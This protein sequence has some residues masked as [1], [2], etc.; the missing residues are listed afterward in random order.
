[1]YQCVCVGASI[2]VVIVM[3]VHTCCSTDL[4]S[5]IVHLMLV[6][7]CWCVHVDVYLQVGTCVHNVA[8]ILT[9]K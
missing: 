1:M 7:A 2:Y 8:F 4:V 3:L 5:V 6:H 9:L